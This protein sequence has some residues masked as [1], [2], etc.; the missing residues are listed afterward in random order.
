MSNLIVSILCVTW[1]IFPKYGTYIL[2]AHSLPFCIENKI[3]YSIT[4]YMVNVL[5]YHLSWQYEWI[6]P[7]LSLWRFNI[8]RSPSLLPMGTPNCLPRFVNFASTFSIS[9]FCLS[10]V[11]LW[12][13]YDNVVLH[14]LSIICLPFDFRLT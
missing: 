5:Y 10:K 14:C 3:L 7:W 13:E 11:C 6:S 12:V 1:P 9:T 4:R 8:T 2:Y